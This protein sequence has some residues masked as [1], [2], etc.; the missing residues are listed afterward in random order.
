MSN[1]NKKAAGKGS[2]RSLL[3]TLLLLVT[4][5][6]C[7]VS[8]YVFWEMK[9]MQTVK[10]E[11]G[12]HAENQAES[13]NTAHAEPLYQPLNTFTVSL[14]PTAAESDRVLF[15]G[16]SLRLVDQKSQQVLE[17]YLPEYRSRIFIMLS[18]LTYEEL[19]TNEGKQQLIARIRDE[20]SK[21]LAT[22]QSVKV[23]DVLFNEFILR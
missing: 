11:D 7:G 2:S 20:V 19:A 12:E 6:A 15:I 8:G 9:K 3:M 18:Q 5:A 16:L 13:E 10:V 4:V 17:K 23:T 1:K 22:N 21:P 14:K